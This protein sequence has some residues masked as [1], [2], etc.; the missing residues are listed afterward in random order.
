[1]ANRKNRKKPNRFN[2]RK[3]QETLMENEILVTYKDIDHKDLET[4][5]IT[6]HYDNY[7]YPTWTNDK[8][9]QLPLAWK[10]AYAYHQ[11][12][13]KVFEIED[14]LVSLL[15]PMTTTI[16]QVDKSK[17]KGL[18]K[19]FIIDVQNSVMKTFFCC[20]KEK[21]DNFLEL[22]VDENLEASQF[23]NDSFA[24]YGVQSILIYFEDVNGNLCDPTDFHN[25]CFVVK[26]CCDVNAKTLEEDELYHRSALGDPMRKYDIAQLRL[27]RAEDNFKVFINEE[28]KPTNFEIITIEDLLL[29]QIDT[30]CKEKDISETARNTYS[31]AYLRAIGELDI[32]SG[33]G[34]MPN[35]YI[36]SSEADKLKQIRETLLVPL[37]PKTE[38]TQNISVC[39]R[40][41]TSNLVVSFLK[42]YTEKQL[43]SKSYRSVHPVFS[44][45]KKNRGKTQSYSYITIDSESLTTLKSER[46]NTVRRS[47]RYQTT[48]EKTMGYRWVREG[49]PQGL[50]DDE[51]IYDISEDTV[52]GIIKYKVKRPISGYTRNAHLPKRSESEDTP[53][54]RA[55][56]KVKSFF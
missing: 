3:R 1:M 44:K 18:P 25:L 10:Q 5:D 53:P 14:T 12:N 48:V 19:A 39:R 34:S 21:L 26:C 50:K 37:I 28:H 24:W 11:R 54:K 55:I 7:Y 41:L 32:I 46:R 47:E 42:A 30:L 22:L 31:N 16:D 17:L 23:Y 15:S 33:D 51:E 6:D 2:V 8:W 52:S 36:A 27:F 29:D 56:T 9:K 49:T 4:F 45:K 13:Q 35:H 38:L 43:V 20:P 40:I